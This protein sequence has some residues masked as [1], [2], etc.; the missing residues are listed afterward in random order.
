MKKED[1]EPGDI[2]ASDDGK[3]AYVRGICDTHIRVYI[4]HQRD[5]IMDEQLHHWE[6]KNPIIDG[7]IVDSKTFAVRFEGF[8]KWIPKNWIQSQP[9]YLEEYEYMMN[10]AKR[11]LKYQISTASSKEEIEYLKYLNLYDNRE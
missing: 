4:N 11:L 6:L 5:V 8:L 7:R 3:I 2:L 1:I 10:V 9:H